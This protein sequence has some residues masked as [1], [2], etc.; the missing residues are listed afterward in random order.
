MRGPESSSHAAASGWLRRETRHGA[1]TALPVVLPS[2]IG[3]ALAVLQAWCVAAILAAA[4]RGGGR[5]AALLRAGLGV[6]AERAAFDTGAAARRR[7]RTDALT[8]LLHA[9]PAS[10]RAQ[11]SGELTATVVDRVEA[12]DG[13]Y[14]RW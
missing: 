2:L 6:I 1:R 11:H 8:R 5:V 7:L 12:M 4:L 3:I 10:L 9:G 13:L 14:S